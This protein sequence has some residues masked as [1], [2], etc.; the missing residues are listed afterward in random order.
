MAIA[1]IL[2]AWIAI[3][4]FGIEK[5]KIVGQPLEERQA[6]ALRGICAVE[7]MIGHIGLYTGNEILYPNRKAGVLFVGV[8]LLLSG[9]GV[10]YSV[11]H[12]KD[13]L[14]HFIRKKILK[15]ILPAYL[16]Y[17]LYEVFKILFIQNVNWDIL[18]N[19]RNFLT[20]L[21]WYVWEQLAFYII[22]YFVYKIMPEKVD[23][24]LGY[25]SFIFICVAFAGKRLDNPWYGSTL[26]FVLGLIYYKHKEKIQK[27]ISRRFWMMV[28]GFGCLLAA[29]TGAFL[30][31]GNESI[32]GN[33]LARNIASLSFCMI[34][35]TV[36]SKVK[37]GNQVSYCLGKC[38]YEIYLIHSFVLSLLWEHGVEPQGLFCWLTAGISVVS[39]LG[40][41]ALETRAFG[42]LI[43]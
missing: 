32:I 41:Y 26:C 39:A 28:V 15:L 8:F 17:F 35:L 43:H 29:S 36:L 5:K 13:Y 4:L 1:M 42:K 6:T 21:N 3:V 34:V 31:L 16:V 25:I 11:E 27:L 30:L 19:I 24:I 33:P 10:A 37:I 18:I 40:I 9:Y 7:I 2:A 22:Y 23:L 20:V 12:K 38:S 14:Q